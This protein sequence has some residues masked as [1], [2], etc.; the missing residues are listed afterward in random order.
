MQ[1]KEDKDD[2]IITQSVEIS[3][4]SSSPPLQQPPSYGDLAEIDESAGATTLS[5]EDMAKIFKGRNLA[6]FLLC[7][8][9]GRH[10]SLRYGLMSKMVQF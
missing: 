8:A 7:L 5:Q 1:N 9:M 4:L 10:I 3:D 6:L 2:N